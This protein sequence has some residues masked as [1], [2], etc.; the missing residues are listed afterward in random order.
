MRATYETIYIV[1]LEASVS[2]MTM[3]S[4]FEKI[5]CICSS[6]NLEDFLKVNQK[7]RRIMRLI[8]KHTFYFNSEGD[9]FN[10][11]NVNNMWGPK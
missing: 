3:C 4:E 9:V 8:K 7:L 5:T 11:N 6:E 10:I 2:S 1:Q